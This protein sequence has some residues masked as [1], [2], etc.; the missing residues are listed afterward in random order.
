MVFP[1]CGQQSA[2]L[3][4]SPTPPEGEVSGLFITRLP[5]R[6]LAWAWRLC[7]AVAVTG[8]A[9][10][11]VA[12]GGRGT[13][14]QSRNPTLALGTEWGKFSSWKSCH[15]HQPLGT[16]SPTPRLDHMGG[17][18]SIIILGLPQAGEA[19]PLSHC[20]GDLHMLLTGFVF[21]EVRSGPCLVPLNPLRAKPELGMRSW[22]FGF[23]AMLGGKKQG[24]NVGEQLP[25]PPCALLS[26]P[27]NRSIRWSLAT[28]QNFPFRS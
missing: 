13:A 7:W 23:G 27:R 14:H 5:S 19:A 6:S 9:G 21:Q 12:T 11:Q 24:A 22:V 16:F 17:G 10:R 18:I 28:P 1:R 4:G 15:Q 3:P 25:H 8:W 26:A 2:V 20:Q